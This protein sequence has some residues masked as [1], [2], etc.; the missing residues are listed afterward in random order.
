MSG[1]AG[2]YGEGGRSRDELQRWV[3]TI[4]KLCCSCP[5]GS[6]LLTGAPHVSPLLTGAPHVSPLLTGVPHVS[7]ET[8]TQALE[9][10]L[11]LCPHDPPFP[12]GRLI[13]PSRLGCQVRW[14][15]LGE[16]R[17]SSL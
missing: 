10:R 6:P 13:L 11:C 12:V 14:K 2:L 16:N 9:V 5:G 1:L 17:L 15:Q 7:L 3:G 4:H 8:S